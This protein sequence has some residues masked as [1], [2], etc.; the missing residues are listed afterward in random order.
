MEDRYDYDIALSFAGEDRA[1]VDQVAK[2]LTK[3]GIKVFYD[4][5]EQ[6]ALWGKDLYIHLIDIYQNRAKYCM[7]F[8]SKYYKQKLWTNHELK[9]VFAR[10]FQS[11]SEYLLPVRFDDTEVPGIVPTTGFLD[12]NSLTPSELAEMARKKVF[13]GMDRAKAYLHPVAE[14]DCSEEDLE[15]IDVGL[16]NQTFLVGRGGLFLSKYISLKHAMI[17]LI[18]RKYYLSDLNTTN[19]TKVN[20]T[21]I[22]NT[23]IEIHNGD[24]LTFGALDFIFRIR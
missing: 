9:A 14:A 8:I 3:M 12:L 18:D 10:A 2:H 24:I 1:Y 4:M 19:G 22:G 11:T 17:T 20:Q 6:V 5:Y 7:V 23:P 13:D 16:S 15:I 21:S